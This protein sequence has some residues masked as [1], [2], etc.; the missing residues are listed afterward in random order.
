MNFNFFL[1]SQRCSFW[2]MFT[3]NIE[4]RAWVAKEKHN[5]LIYGRPGKISGLISPCV[6][7]KEF[8]RSPPSVQSHQLHRVTLCSGNDVKQL[9][10]LIYFLILFNATKENSTFNFWFS[11]KLQ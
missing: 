9:T 6:S 1:V 5:D 11:A 4:L 8:Y 10:L 2:C 3:E 7:A